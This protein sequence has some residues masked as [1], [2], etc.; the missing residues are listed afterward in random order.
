MGTLIGAV[1]AIIAGMAVS[2]A[3]VVGVVQTVKDEP[4]APAGQVSTGQ[5]DVPIVNY[6]GK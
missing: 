5:V 4:K 1:L 3:A 6:G 2:T